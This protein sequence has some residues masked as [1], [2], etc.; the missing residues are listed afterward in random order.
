MLNVHWVQDFLIDDTTLSEQGF[1]NSDVTQ[2]GNVNILDIVSI[3]NLIFED[4]EGGL[5]Q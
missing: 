3:V 4:I 1:I 2:D 5:D